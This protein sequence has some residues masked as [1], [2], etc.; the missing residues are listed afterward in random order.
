MPPGYEQKLV[1]SHIDPFDLKLGPDP[2]V[3][4]TKPDAAP[5]RCKARYYAS[6]QSELLYEFTNSL[7]KRTYFIWKSPVQITLKAM[8]VAV[9]V[10]NA[11]SEETVCHF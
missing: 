6:D 1:L 4:F 5:L 7:Q 8:V 2:P 9:R 3:S 10:V 11:Q